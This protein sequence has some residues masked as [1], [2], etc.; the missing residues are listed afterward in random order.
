MPANALGRVVQWVEQRAFNPCV[1]GSN[2]TAST[3]TSHASNAWGRVAQLVRAGN[4]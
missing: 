3:S 4:S 2:P 1:V